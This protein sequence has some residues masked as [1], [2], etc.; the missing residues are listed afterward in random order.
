MS[1]DPGVQQLGRQVTTGWTLTLYPSAGEAGGS[2]Q[3]ARRR[4]VVVTGPAADPE[5]A[6]IEAARRARATVRRYCAANGLN[7]FGT[8]TYAGNGCH[9]PLALRRDVAD[10]FRRLRAV[11]GGQPFPYVWVPEWHKTDHGL[12]AHFAVGRYIQY[13]LIRQAWGRGFVH[14]KL[15]GDLPVGSSKRD[16]ARVAARYLAKY[17]GKAVD[18]Q[19]VP[20]LHRY[21]RAQGF[22]PP[23]VRLTGGRSADDVMDQA[24]ALMGGHQ[25]TVRWSSADVLD[26]QA[27]PALWAQWR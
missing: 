16:E 13:G 11:L 19:R 25:P 22:T 12:H 5:R 7:R 10:F 3:Y 14:I 27:P 21:E 18:E 6:R 15:I 2:F 23:T 26:W 24:V 8:L 20:G 17:V 9:D 1:L 4:R